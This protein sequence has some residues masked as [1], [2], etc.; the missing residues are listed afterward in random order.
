MSE[1]ALVLVAPNEASLDEEVQRLL[2]RFG[3][4]ALMNE[5][6]R[7]LRPRARDKLLTSDF[8]ALGEII[9]DE[10]RR[11]L[12]GKKKTAHPKIAAIIANSLT[13]QS[14]EANYRR[15]MKRLASEDR[16][17][18]QIIA[19]FMISQ[20][21]YPYARFIATCEA[22]ANRFDTHTIGVV[23]LEKANA[24]ISRLQLHGIIVTDDM[25]M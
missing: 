11:W 1:N 15:I 7:A 22:C 8:E 3:R 21:E 6:A 19:A 13:G 20:S 14:Y 5:V 18:R 24:V 23:A 17:F 2:H 12:D 9:Q 10:A 25:T 16:N 4:T